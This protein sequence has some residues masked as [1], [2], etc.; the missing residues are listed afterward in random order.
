MQKHIGYTMKA[1][2]GYTPREEMRELA[3]QMNAIANWQQDSAQQQTDTARMLIRAA[4]WLELASNFTCG[5]GM[6][7]CRGGDQCTSDH[8]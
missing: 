6:V 8:K 2:T 5:Q 7:G 1:P 4:G 3:V